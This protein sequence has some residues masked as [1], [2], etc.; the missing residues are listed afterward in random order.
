MDAAQGHMTWFPFWLSCACA[1]VEQCVTLEDKYQQTARSTFSLSTEVTALKKKSSYNVN[2]KKKETAT[3]SLIAA[4]REELIF[5]PQ[6]I[7]A[8][9]LD[10]RVSLF[11]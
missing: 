11:L 4:R 2:K 3:A 6:L 10:E 8:S 5:P 9:Q 7:W 1:Q